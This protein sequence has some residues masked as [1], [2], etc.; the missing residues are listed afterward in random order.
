MLSP[1]SP[2]ISPPIVEPMRIPIQTELDRI[3]L[4]PRNEVRRIGGHVA[5]LPELLTA[6]VAFFVLRSDIFGD[7]ATDPYPHPS[8]RN[9]TFSGPLSESEQAQ[10]SIM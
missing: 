9:L 10:S 5:K 6:T 4:L 2:G 3:D 1:H 7:H 8:A